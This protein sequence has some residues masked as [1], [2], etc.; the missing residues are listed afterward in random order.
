M[1]G[2]SAGLLKNDELSLNQ[3]YYALLLPSGNDAA[4]AIAD[5]F[6]SLKAVKDEIAPK[7]YKFQDSVNIRFFIKEMNMYAKQL[8]MV[9]T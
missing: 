9:N 5:Y 4:L 7:S 1:T 3:L 8:G 6:G 2:T